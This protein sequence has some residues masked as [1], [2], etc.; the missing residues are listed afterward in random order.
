MFISLTLKE[1]RKQMFRAPGITKKHPNFI[2]QFKCPTGRCIPTNWQCDGDAD[3]ENG[4]DEPVSCRDE[5]A[6][7]CEESYFRCKNQR[8]IPGRW[9][10]DYDDDCGD[11][12]DETECL[13]LYRNCSESERP[14]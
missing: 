1:L 7:I 13:N 12:S 4:E 6:K 9:R 8:C 3:C 11:N 10:C 2:P 14:W 5:S